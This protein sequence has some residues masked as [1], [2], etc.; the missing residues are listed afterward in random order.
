MGPVSNNRT[1]LALG[2]TVLA[3]VFPCAAWYLV[4]SREVAHQVA[5][6][7][8]HAEE[9][10]RVTAERLARQLT[11]RLN[12]LRDAEAQRPYYHYQPYFHDP[13]GAAEIIAIH[14]SALNKLCLSQ[15]EGI[16]RSTIYH[17]LRNKN[18]TLKTVAKLIHCCL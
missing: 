16:P 3:V 4:G 2:L 5:E 6:V 17:S 10:A 9:D 12:A 7:T 1:A 14:L 8:G 15:E 18:P 13:E 11:Q